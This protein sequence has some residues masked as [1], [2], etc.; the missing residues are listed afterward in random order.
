MGGHFIDILC[1]VYI[2]G[3]VVV[4]RWDGLNLLMSIQT[5]RNYYVGIN[6]L[7]CHFICIIEPG[8]DKTI[9]IK[10]DVVIIIAYNDLVDNPT[11]NNINYF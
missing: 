3:I 4:A 1:H 2:Y 9:N 10:G 8:K 6:M 5:M 7:G 11:L